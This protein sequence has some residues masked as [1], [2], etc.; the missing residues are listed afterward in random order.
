MGTKK[1]LGFIVFHSRYVCMES[2]TMQ[3]WLISYTV[4]NPA[5]VPNNNNRRFAIRAMNDLSHD[6]FRLFYPEHFYYI[7]HTHKRT[8]VA[9][10]VA[11][12]KKI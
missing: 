2:H 1:I 4:E 12:K 6:C 11:E 9:S 5:F 10:R 8:M 3:W 7:P